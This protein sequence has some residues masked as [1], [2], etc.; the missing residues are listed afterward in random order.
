MNPILWAYLGVGNSSTDTANRCVG[1]KEFLSGGGGW[2]ELLETRILPIKEL[3]CPNI[4]IGNP[5]G[6]LPGLQQADAW[7]LAKKAGLTLLSD[8]GAFVRA[9]WAAKPEGINL[10]AYMGGVNNSSYIKAGATHR[11]RL[12]RAR[13]CYQPIFDGGIGLALDGDAEIHP[14]SDASEIVDALAE[15]QPDP[16]RPQYLEAMWASSW[17]T[18]RPC[19]VL[20][21]EY[22]RTKARASVKNA[23]VYRIIDNSG[24]DPLQVNKPEWWLAEGPKRAAQIRAD[25]HGIVVSADPFVDAKM[26]FSVLAVAPTS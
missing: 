23:G 21:T 14:N 20:E 9:M 2:E 10:M 25:G 3:G 22:Q 4:I 5:A 13:Q 7:A 18:D 11:D 12:R 24:G 6:E 8:T 1:R 26:P 15:F 16:R 19:V 17:G